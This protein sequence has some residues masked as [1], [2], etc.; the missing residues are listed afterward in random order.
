[1]I[2]KKNKFYYIFSLFKTIFLNFWS[3]VFS[4]LYFLRPQLTY[5]IYN[6][7]SPK[8]YLQ[9]YQKYLNIGHS[10]HINSLSRL[11]FFLTFLQPTEEKA[12]LTLMEEFKELVDSHRV[13]CTT[14]S[15]YTSAASAASFYNVCIISFLL[16]IN[17]PICSVWL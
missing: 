1:M 12:Q 14:V 16:L 6:S 13:I 3:E 15:F 2:L 10:R 4:K 17:H 5:A 7:K 9:I 11:Y 8:A